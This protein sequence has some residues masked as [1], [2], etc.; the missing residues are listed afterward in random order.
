MKP[1][2]NSTS[3]TDKIEWLVH[4]DNGKIIGAIFFDLKKVFDVVDHEILLR[5]LAMYGIRGTSLR[6]F[7][8]YL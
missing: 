2:R 6:W 7:E 1:L 3:I 5:K 8:S 4:I